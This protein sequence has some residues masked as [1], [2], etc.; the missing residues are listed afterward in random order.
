MNDPRLDRDT[1]ERMLRGEPTG[2]PRLAEVLAAAR[3]RATDGETD[4]EAAALAAFRAAQTRPHARP[5]RRRLPALISVKAALVGFVLLLTGGVAMA[6]TARHLPGPLG[7]RPSH[8]TTTPA[9]PDTG[10]THITP[11]A[12]VHPSP[13]RQA[14]PPGHSRPTPHPPKDKAHTWKTPKGKAK[15]NPHKLQP[16]G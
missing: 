16:T 1:A 10:R 7:S 11:P 15:R 9:A 8:H 4:A 3:P 12:S 6:A 14:F 13:R 5:S 2:P